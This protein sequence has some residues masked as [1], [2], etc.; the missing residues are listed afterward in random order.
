MIFFITFFIQRAIAPVIPDDW[1]K[2][3]DKEMIYRITDEAFYTC[4]FSVEKLYE[5]LIFVGI[6]NPEI[7]LKQ[8]II[9]TGWF[10][11]KA[12]ILG[13]NPF[14]M[15][16]SESRETTAMGWEWADFYDGEYHKVSI[17]NYWYDAVKDYKLWQDY[18]LNGKILD[19]QEYYQFLKE[20]PYA[21]NPHYVSIVKQVDLPNLST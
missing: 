2:Q 20:L 4:P 3:M 11:S 21:R 9:E 14:G 10:K 19:Q 5:A 18:W 17:Y 16:Y 13:Q 12:F 1:L 7:V 15:H 6:Q 8:C